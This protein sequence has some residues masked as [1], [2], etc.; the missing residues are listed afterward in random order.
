MRAIVTDR[1]TDRPT[2]RQMPF[3][4]SSKEG[5]VL[6]QPLKLPC[7]VYLPNRVAKSAMTEGFADAWVRGACPLPAWH[8]VVVSLSG[9]YCYRYYSM[10][11]KYRM[12]P[13]IQLICH[14]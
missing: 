11:R 4:S 14:I 13:S 7:G 3:D 12:S 2:D 8:L 10:E 9:Y 5:G 1:Q 6:T